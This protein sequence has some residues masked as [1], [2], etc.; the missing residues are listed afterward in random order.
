MKQGSE[1]RIAVIGL[2]GFPGIQGGV[3]SH[4]RE[5]WPR[6]TADGS[7]NAVV[8]R[9]K[10]YVTDTE[11]AYTG[12]HF[13]DLPSTRIKGF[14]AF[15][16]SFIAACD[17]IRRRDC[18]TVSIHNIGPG[19]VTPLLRLFGHNVVLTYHS[20]NYE[21]KKWGF[22][23]RSV[24]RLGEW[25][26][27][28][29]A[30]RIIFV[31]RFQME[32]YGE[33]IRRKSFYIPNGISPAS[34]TVA[35]DFLAPHRLEPGKYILSVGRITPEKGFDTL[36]Q[37]AQ[38]LPDGIK[39][40]IAGAPDHDAA[41]LDTLK[42]LD[43]SGRTVFTGFT[44]GEELRQL[45]SHARLFVLSSV[46]EGFP[47]VLLEAMSFSLPTVATDIAGTRLMPRSENGVYPIFVNP[48]SVDEMRKGIDNAL[49]NGDHQVNYQ[50]D[51][52]TWEHVA[53]R[54]AE[55]FNSIK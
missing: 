21:H 34:R 47:I 32:K 51:N 24:L 29:F 45:Y 42:R 31:N 54:T 9:R 53:D 5:I 14:E 39:L 11:M 27:L 8:Y 7:H 4:C 41:Y 13:R 18:K 17:I 48:G 22:T 23:G 36:I 6:M 30:S 46:N 16:H 33:S 15:F 44:A 35:T 43:T 12:I 38:R 50:L 52:F 28:K 2:R 49:L 25:L 19:L 26:S 20:P 3:E 10:P 40:A 55:V 37:S 1:T